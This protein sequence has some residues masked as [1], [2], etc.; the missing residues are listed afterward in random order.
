M[1]KTQDK[2]EQRKIEHAEYMWQKAQIRAALAKSELDTALETFRTL[3][4]ELTDE[5]IVE[6]REKA[7]EQ[8][9]RV[10]EYLMEEKEKYLERLGIQQD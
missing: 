10:E 2:K 3:V 5:Q 9:K 4:G 1:S 6:T 7:K 8:Y